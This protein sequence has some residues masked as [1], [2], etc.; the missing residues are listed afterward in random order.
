[1][2]WLGT[3]KLMSEPEFEIDFINHFFSDGHFCDSKKVQL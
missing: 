1:M 2:R 3:H